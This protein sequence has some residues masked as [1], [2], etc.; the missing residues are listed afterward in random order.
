MSGL[1]SISL[2]SPS[3]SEKDEGTTS[4]RNSPRYILNNVRRH[5]WYLPGVGS[6]ECVFANCVDQSGKS[7]RVAIHRHHGLLREQ[8]VCMRACPCNRAVGV[9]CIPWSLPI[10]RAASRRA[11]SNSLLQL[12]EPDGI[13]FLIEFWLTDQ[14]DLQQ[15]VLGRFQ[16]RSEDGPLQESPSDK[17]CASSRS[18]R[19]SI[20]SIPA[21]Y[22]ES[23]EVEQQL[24][25]V[26]PRSRQS[27]IRDDVL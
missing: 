3:V 23:A 17:W 7:A 11:K 13:Q 1:L 18:G 6:N 9:R 10:Q 4:R 2:W 14:Y 27:E 25:F 8:C 19:W 5:P 16:I 21:T 15:L 12:P 20:L 24:A 22:Q 26:L